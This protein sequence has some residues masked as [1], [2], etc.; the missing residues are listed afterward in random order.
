MFSLW[1]NRNDWQG[2]NH[3]T[4]WGLF[5]GR[6][7]ITSQS[8]SL[9]NLRELNNLQD[10]PCSHTTIICSLFSES[11]S[12][13]L[14]QFILSIVVLFAASFTLPA[15]CHSLTFSVDW[16]KHFL[17]VSVKRKE[18]KPTLFPCVI[19]P[20]TNH[21]HQATVASITWASFIWFFRLQCL[22]QPTVCNR[23]RRKRHE[24]E[25]WIMS[26]NSFCLVTVFT[27]TQKKKKKELQSFLLHTLLA[28]CI[29]ARGDSWLGRRVCTSIKRQSCRNW[30]HVPN[31]SAAA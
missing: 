12:L 11:V 4:V 24:E 7:F 1:S 3:T 18:Q 28:N 29:K 15:A 20:F 23:R 10:Y 6:S 26:V 14:T 2:L 8:N 31:T 17:K 25:T 9:H 30:D 13:L 27:L 16:T 5:L 19:T 21:T 22:I